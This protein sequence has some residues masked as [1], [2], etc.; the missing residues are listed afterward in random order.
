MLKMRA[1]TSGLALIPNANANAWHQQRDFNEVIYEDPIYQELDS[2]LEDQMASEIA[3][4]NS[5]AFTIEDYEQESATY[6]PTTGILTIVAGLSYS[7]EQDG[8]D[9][10]PRSARGSWSACCRSFSS[11]PRECGR[12]GA[13]RRWLAP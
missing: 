6:D 2:H 10:V 3:E 4:T 8:G 9:T 1:R 13:A 7:G 12:A 5:C 11:D